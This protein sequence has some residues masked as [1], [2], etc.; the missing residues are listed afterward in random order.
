MWL[1]HSPFVY[2]RVNKNGKKP[3][4]KVMSVLSQ[5]S[6]V[7]ISNLKEEI[8]GGCDLPINEITNEILNDFIEDFYD[9]DVEEINEIFG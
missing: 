8:N 4:I 1:P 6:E 3:K 5:L 2:S 7:V 9:N